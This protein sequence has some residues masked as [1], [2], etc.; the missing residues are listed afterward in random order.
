M[1]SYPQLW[2]FSEAA[3]ER[4]PGRLPETT[5]KQRVQGAKSRSAKQRSVI[6]RLFP[7]LRE[8]T[9][10]KKKKTHDFAKNPRRNH[11]VEN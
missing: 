3:G 6:L 11:N 4:I 5:Q 8:K 7:P 1:S 2:C 9:S 10:A